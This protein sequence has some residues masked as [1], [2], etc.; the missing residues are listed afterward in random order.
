MR[1]KKYLYLLITLVI[2]STGLVGCVSTDRCCD[3]DIATR[4]AGHAGYH[5][6]EIYHNN[7]AKAYQALGPVSVT[8]D[9]DTSNATV[10]RLLKEKAARRGGDAVIVTDSYERNGN[11]TVKG[12]IIVWNTNQ[13]D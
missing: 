10:H 8:V 5:H 3:E 12:K 4:H 6:V 1:M 11:K 9:D 13:H 2:A 7:P